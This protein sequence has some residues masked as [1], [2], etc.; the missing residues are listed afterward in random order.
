ME[1]DAAEADAVVV[2]DAHSAAAAV[3]N[4]CHFGTVGDR[5]ARRR[6]HRRVLLEPVE[7]TLE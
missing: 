5:S 1:T 2:A 6:N 7:L 3:D 4:N